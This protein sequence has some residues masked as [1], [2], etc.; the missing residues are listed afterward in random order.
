MIGPSG[1]PTSNCTV[2]TLWSV[3]GCVVEVVRFPRSI[4][5]DIGVGDL[6]MKC[7]LVPCP[8]GHHESDAEDH[9]GDDFQQISAQR[10]N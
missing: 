3:W 10:L 6:V 5:D 9:C 2:S 1:R 8:A 4:D 7:L